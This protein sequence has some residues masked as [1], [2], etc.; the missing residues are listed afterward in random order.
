MRGSGV[1][2][3]KT[4]LVAAGL[5]FVPQPPSVYDLLFCSVSQ[6]TT[7]LCGFRLDDGEK[8]AATTKTLHRSEAAQ[9]HRQ[10]AL[11]VASQKE[12]K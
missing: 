12:V 6:A 4:A 2:S 3:A 1:R 9:Q 10:S 7:V 5:K 11:L 8:M